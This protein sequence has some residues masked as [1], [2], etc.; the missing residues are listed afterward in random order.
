MTDNEKLSLNI[1]GAEIKRL[2]EAALR[3]LDPFEARDVVAKMQEII[4]RQQAE[5]E[6]LKAEKVIACS[7]IP[8]RGCGKVETKM[9]MFSQA[10]ESIENEAIKEFAERLKEKNRYPN[11]TIYV[12]WIDNLVKEMVG[13][14]NAE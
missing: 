7:L 6:R 1:N 9:K 8:V 13:D 11:G 10:V 5:I 14:N 4:N 2:A 3:C 12:E